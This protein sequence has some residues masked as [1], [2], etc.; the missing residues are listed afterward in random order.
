MEEI[1]K[2]IENDDKLANLFKTCP[3]FILK[4]IKKYTY[5]AGK[6]NLMQE[7]KYDYTYII[8]SG[9]VKVYLISANGK[10]V[11]LDIYNSGMLIGE[12]EAIIDK[13]YSASIINITDVCLLRLKNEDFREW[14]ACD[15]AFANKLIHNLSSQIHHLTR[16]TERYS[17]YSAIEQIT[18]FLLNADIKDN[19]ITREQLTY[20]VDTSYRNINRILRKLVDLKV[21]TVVEGNINI[22]D[23]ENLEKIF[24]QNVDKI[25]MK[26]L[27]DRRK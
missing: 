20:E 1:L 10:S 11:V 16:R 14:L 13:P 27:K 12:Q 4:R 19:E 9:Q 6:F 3:L 25:S 24:F 26:K 7:R 5:S 22:L 18:K 15:N 17:L 2:I 8:V 21:I 23:K